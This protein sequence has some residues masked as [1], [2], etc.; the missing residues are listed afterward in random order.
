MRQYKL[1]KFK[2]GTYGVIAKMENR[3]IFVWFDE[4]DPENL[5]KIQFQKLADEEDI[6]LQGKFPNWLIKDLRFGKK[7]RTTPINLSEEAAIVLSNALKDL[8]SFKKYKEYE[9]EMEKKKLAEN[10][11]QTKQE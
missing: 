8:I 3:R 2:E 7:L 11:E 4:S 5:I 10:E 6:S 9:E 1:S